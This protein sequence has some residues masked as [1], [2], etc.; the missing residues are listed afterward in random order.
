MFGASTA[1][2]L[3]RTSPNAQVIVVDRYRNNPGAAS[4]DLDKIIR[5]D[6]PDL[7]YMRLALEAQD[8]WRTDPI[9]KPF[10]HESGM[11]FAEEIGMGR[12]SLENYKSLGVETGAEILP[13]R[14]HGPGSPSSQANWT[15]VAENFYNSRS[16]WGEAEE[17]MKSIV[18]A[19]ND[20]G[21]VFEA[22]VQ[23]G[24]GK[25]LAYSRISAQ[26]I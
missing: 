17:A 12:A 5:A 4:N 9:F 15:D 11:L 1:L 23:S 19:A 8:I 2:H 13:H 24:S 22:T 16:G 14:K 21:V 25:E 20:E 7:V 18:Q 10:Y 6:Y 3:K 26:N